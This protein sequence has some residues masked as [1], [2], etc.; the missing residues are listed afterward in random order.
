MR[1]R[2]PHEFKIEA[3]MGGTDTKVYL[4]DKLVEGLFSYNL[5]GAVDE[6]TQL[7]LNFSVIRESKIKG[8]GIVEFN[9]PLPEDKRARKALYEQLKTEFEE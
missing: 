8:E 4:E 5:Q 9:F 1:L 2:E 6:R 7:D 3:G